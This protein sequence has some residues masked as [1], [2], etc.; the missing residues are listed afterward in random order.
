MTEQAVVPFATIEPNPFKVVSLVHKHL[1]AT[2][3]ILAC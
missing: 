1:L 3:K 2:T